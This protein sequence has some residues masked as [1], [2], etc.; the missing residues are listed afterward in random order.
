M[1]AAF[2]LFLE[3][4]EA[5]SLSKVAVLRQTAQSN[6]SRQIVDLER[7]CGGSLFARTGR[8]VVLSEFG[9][10]IQPWIAEW[11]RQTDQLMDEIRSTAGVPSGQVRIGVLPSMAH[12]LM[13]SL[14]RDLAVSYPQVRLVIREGQ[15]S[16]IEAW[17]DTHQVDMALL[18]RSQRPS[19]N[20]ETCLAELGTYLVGAPGSPLTQLRETSQRNAIGQELD[21]VETL[22]FVRLDG[23]PL[24]LP[25]R[26]SRWRDVLDD[27]A[28]ATSI[29]LLPALEAD[30]LT[31]QREV[32]ASGA[33]YAVLGPYAIAD[34]VRCGRLSARRI[35]RPA[36]QRF[37]ALAIY[38]KAPPT[39][40]SRTAMQSLKA[41]FME[42]AKLINKPPSA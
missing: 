11:M 22:D 24:V 14:Y 26:P 4:A 35:E 41:I 20:D 39:L 34:D 28:R 30:S 10:R 42:G 9:Q 37:L 23:V 16:E 31:I 2:K 1:L 12:P 15:G 17:L 6:I 25:C 29:T 32:A 27:A 21:Q 7:R 19:S 33:A 36:L 3:V 5:G 8:G 13:T 18:L 38:K 40:A